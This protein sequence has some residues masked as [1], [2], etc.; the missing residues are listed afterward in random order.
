MVKWSISTSYLTLHP[1]AVYITSM[2]NCLEAYASIT[3]VSAQPSISSI[4]ELHYYKPKA[5]G[6]YWEKPVAF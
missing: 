3:T 5:S 2:L 1:M 6:V 4:K